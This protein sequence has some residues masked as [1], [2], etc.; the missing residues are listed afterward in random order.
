MK[1]YSRNLTAR[2]ATSELSDS[3]I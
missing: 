2:I 3:K 1:S